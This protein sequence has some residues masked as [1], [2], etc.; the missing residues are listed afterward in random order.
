MLDAAARAYLSSPQ[1]AVVDGRVLRVSRIFDWYG[2]D[3]VARYAER[4]AG[5]RP[6]KERAIL[7]AV[8]RVRVRRLR[9]HWPRT[10]DVALRFLDYDWTTQRP[11]RSIVTAGDE[12]FSSWR[13]TPEL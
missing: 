9:P 4:S 11:T 6:A 12:R 1:G 13:S 3:F 8:G 5:E 7:G 10:P 2:D